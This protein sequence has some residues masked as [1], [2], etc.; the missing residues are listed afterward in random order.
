MS[1]STATIQARWDETGGGDPIFAAVDGMNC[2]HLPPG[3][4]AS[5][6][7][8]LRRGLF[9]IFLP[10]PPEGPDGVPIDPEFEIEVVSDPA[11]CNTHPDYGLASAEPMISVYRRPRPVANLRYVT[12]GGAAF[13]IKDGSPMT[14]DPETGEPASMQLMADAREASLRTQARSAARTHLERAEPLT[15]EQLGLIEA[16]E[17]Q[18]YMAQSGH[19]LGGDFMAD[20]APP[21]LGPDAMRDGEPGLGDNFRNPVFGHFEMWR[22]PRDEETPEER[23]FRESVI[24]GYDVYFVRPFWIRDA[25]HINTVGLGNPVKRTCATCHNASLTGMDFAPGWVD[26]GTTNQPWARAADIDPDVPLFRLTCKPTAAPHPFLGREILTHDPGRALINGRCQDIGA[27]TMQQMRGL[28]GRAPYFSNGSAK[29]LRALVDFYDVRFN[30]Q[31]SEQEKEDL[32]N[33]LSVL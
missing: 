4:P 31:Y 24:R 23:A 19:S 5:H 16:L 17:G 28:A 9:R 29:T 26:I 2:P 25:T 30:A 18:L 3:D 20:D 21:A 32:V 12:G 8:L 33:F 7:L 6:S 15:D 11:G 27:I 14:R 22:E 10:W 1:L 13:N